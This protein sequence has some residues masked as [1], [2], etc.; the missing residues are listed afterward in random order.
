M[1]YEFKY[2]VAPISRFRVVQLAQP[3]ANS[4]IPAQIEVDG[5]AMAV[6]P[7]FWRS[8]CARYAISDSI[9][10]Y[11]DYSEVFRRIT[12][13]SNDDQV[14]ICVERDSDGVLRAL[15]VSNPHRGFMHPGELIDLVHQ[16]GHE[17]VRY[18][19]GV[20]T[21]EHTPASGDFPFAIGCDD[22]KRRF[23]L[24]TPIDG[25]GSPRI[26]LSLLR[27]VCTNG[28]VGYTPTFRTEIR[29]G[30]DA[31]H[32]IGR[33]LESFDNGEGY[34]ALRQ[35]FESAQTSWASLNEVQSL[36]RVLMRNRNGLQDAADVIE[37]Y[38]AAT[39]RPHELYGFANLDAVTAKRQRILPTDCY[40]Y[41]L[42]N[43]ASEVATHNANPDAS[44]ALNS[45]IGTVIAD[46]YDMEGTGSN[47]T[48]FKDFFLQQGGIGTEPS[49]N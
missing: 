3:S 19:Q 31:T 36:Y 8:F 15:A 26:Y 12:E 14:R 30:N 41:D 16:Y 7:R 44:R 11:F 46:E 20:I 5:Q 17:R 43:F 2:A 4:R 24:E 38:Y 9:F 39:G 40:V 13:R 29:V 35:R 42:L 34:A 47:V 18:D 25:F 45:H 49:T 33:A 10:R 22:F 1:G 32:A 21:S 23:V 27:L 37:R 48:E 28:M 6:T